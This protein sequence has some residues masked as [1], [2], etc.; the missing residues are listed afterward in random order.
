MLTEAPFQVTGVAR[1]QPAIAH[2]QY[3]NV[4]LEHAPPG[5]EYG[6]SGR[7]RRVIRHGAPSHDGANRHPRTKPR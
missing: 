7:I 4:V 6:A 5:K 3:V 2:A 1:I